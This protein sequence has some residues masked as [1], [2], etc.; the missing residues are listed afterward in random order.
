M[1]DVYSDTSTR[2]AILA[3]SVA[4]FSYFQP[5]EPTDMAEDE[6]WYNQDDYTIRRF[7]DGAWVVR[8]EYIPVN[9]QRCIVLKRASINGVVSLGAVYVLR[10]GNAF[11]TAPIYD[12]GF[13]PVSIPGYD[14]SKTQY[15]THD[16][17]GVPTWAEVL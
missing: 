4:Q 7:A 17:F 8:G 15:L 10:D 5:T 1:A 9:Q 11:A 6:L 12:G 2:S 14:A 16:A 13:D 3:A